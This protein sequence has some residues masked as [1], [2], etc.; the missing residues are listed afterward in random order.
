MTAKHGARA[1]LHVRITMHYCARDQRCIFF[2][3]SVKEDLNTM[4]LSH[5]LQHEMK[6]SHHLQQKT[7]SF[8]KRKHI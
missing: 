3:T 4:K 6:L 5:H 1:D 2:F 7:K 8:K